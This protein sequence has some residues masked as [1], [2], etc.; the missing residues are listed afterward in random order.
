[1][2]PNRK[3]LVRRSKMANH[4]FLLLCSVISIC[5]VLSAVQ[6]AES[7]PLVEVDKRGDDR[8]VGVNLPFIYTMDLLTGKKGTGLGINVLSGLVRVDM[9]T[10]NK[11]QNGRRPVRVTFLG[12]KL[13][14]SYPEDHP[15]KKPLKEHP[16]KETEHSEP[17]PAPN[18]LDAAPEANLIKK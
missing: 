3:S 2:T 1:M 13:Y 16:T 7:R 14:D 15:S 11:A 9:D 10:R 4:S 8:V 6:M 17:A 18:P 12:S 5:G